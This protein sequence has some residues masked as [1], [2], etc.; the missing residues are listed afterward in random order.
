MSG[1]GFA[2][3]AQSSSLYD[4]DDADIE[5][6]S[7]GMDAKS[8]ADPPLRDKTIA[9]DAQ[10]SDSPETSSSMP[11]HT[12]TL[13]SLG[14]FPGV[15]WA[16]DYQCNFGSIGAICIWAWVAFLLLPTLFFTLV[17]TCTCHLHLPPATCRCDPFPKPCRTSLSPRLLGP[18]RASAAHRRC[19]SCRR[20]CRST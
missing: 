8:L 14:A 2:Y 1:L 5:R 17:R 12:A 7:D 9:T 6:G 20:G 4:K 15:L 11:S 18:P 3:A 10:S 16:D 19:R 13:I